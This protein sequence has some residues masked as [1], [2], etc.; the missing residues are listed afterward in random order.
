MKFE[1]RMGSVREGSDAMADAVATPKA[2]TPVLNAEAVPGGGLPSADL[3]PAPGNPLPNMGPGTPMGTVEAMGASPSQQAATSPPASPK[4]EALEALD[5]TA[6]PEPLGERK[7]KKQRLEETQETVA[8]LAGL[9]QSTLTGLKDLHETVTLTNQQQKELQAEIDQ[10]AKQMNCDAVTAK[11]VYNS[12]SDFQRSLNNGVWQLSGGK[13]DS[14]CSVKEV[15]L[16][17]EDYSKQ[18]SLRLLESKNEV[19][20]QHASTITSIKEVTSAVRAL[21]QAIRAGTEQAAG[22]AP[23]APTVTATPAVEVSTSGPPAPKAAPTPATAA[24]GAPAT[25]ATPAVGLASAAADPAVMPGYGSAPAPAAMFP[26]P[27]MGGPVFQAAAAPAPAQR[28]GRIRVAL[29]DGSVAARAVSPHGRLPTGVTSEW[30]NEYG[31]GTVNC[32]GYVY[33]VLPDS[34]LEGSVALN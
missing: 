34:Y 28:A 14:Q 26:P 12:L 29:R 4:D 23:A 9:V 30:A 27:P 21:E 16:H 22:T 3:L 2:A 20:A 11:V 6:L 10:L 7:S 33:R 15:L 25:P 17:M 31:L 32:G 19:R 24:M 5:A 1:D 8:Q 18:T 13:R